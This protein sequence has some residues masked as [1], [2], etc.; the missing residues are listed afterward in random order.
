[1]TDRRLRQPSTQPS[2]A[3]TRCPWPTVGDP[4]YLAY[5]DDEWGVPVHDDGKIYEFLVL[6]AFQAGLSWRTVL[7][8]RENFRK[9]FAGFDYR[10]VARFGHR[11]VARLLKDPGIIRNRQ[12]IEAAITNAQR[13]IE[14]QREYG[15]FAAYMWSWVKGKPIVHRFR[16]IEDYPPYIEEAVAWAK[17]LKRRGFKF[18]GPTV[19]YAHMQAVGMVNDHTVDCFRR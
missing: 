4:L 15:A 8:K 2:P 10:K 3:V 14:V 16:A 7:Y 13:F 12:K 17:D 5:H 9:A 6:E 19:V 11:E 18:L 1:M